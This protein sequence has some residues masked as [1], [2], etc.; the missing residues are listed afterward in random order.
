MRTID[1]YNYEEFFLDYLEGNLSDSEVKNLERFLSDH[2]DLK[3]EL[4]EMRLVVVEEEAIEFDKSALKQIPFENDFDEF[5]VAKLEGDLEKE[6]EL[7]FS[8]Y[9]NINLIEKAQYQLY[10]KT[11]L[12][13]DLEILYPDKEELRRKDRKMIPYWLLSGVGIAA[14]VLVLF[15]VW[16]TSISDKDAEQLS[17]NKVAYID[18]VKK[19]EIKPSDEAKRLE[20]LVK[21]TGTKP[22]EANSTNLD[23]AEPETAAVKTPVKMVQAENP[24]VAEKPAE[25]IAESFDSE[26]EKISLPEVTQTTALEILANAEIA[27]HQIESSEQEEE[28]AEVVASNSGLNNLG[29]SWKSSVKEKKKNNSLLY[30]V[31]KAG[32]DKLGAI[33]GKKVQ[34][35]KQYD[36][37][38]EKTRVN[39]NTKGIGFS[40]SIK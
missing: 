38:T 23:K 13:A 7:A 9:L 6:E 30:A 8:N 31:A 35:E 10:E 22:A 17:G 18:T 25:Q 36:S 3:E 12:S 26:P 28:M 24:I 40:T 4:N 32:V 39:F 37:E 14:S 15:T 2:P 5:C 21:N 19:I 11:K 1:R 20:E 34:L 33:A 16:N 29:M 27:E